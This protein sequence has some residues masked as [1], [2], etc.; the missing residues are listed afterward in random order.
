MAKD[1][2]FHKTE[3][4]AALT[5]VEI[6]GRIFMKILDDNIKIDHGCVLNHYE[7]LA[8]LTAFLVNNNIHKSQLSMQEFIIV[9]EELGENA[10]EE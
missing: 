3:A 6:D 7:V 4:L 8:E 10:G 9:L 1:G 2:S 5:D